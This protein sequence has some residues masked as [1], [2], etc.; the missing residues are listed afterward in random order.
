M[1]KYTAQCQAHSRDSTN[2]SCFLMPRESFSFWLRLEGHLGPGHM[3]SAGSAASLTPYLQMEPGYMGLEN[4]SPDLEGGGV[5][6]G[7][8]GQSS[9]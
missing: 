2:G 5:A 8:K 4:L 1:K 6:R 9:K 3:I 7:R